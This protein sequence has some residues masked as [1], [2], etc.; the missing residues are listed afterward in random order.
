MNNEA[1]ADARGISPPGAKIGPQVKERRRQAVRRRNPSPSYCIG[2]LILCTAIVELGDGLLLHYLR[3]YLSPHSLVLVDIFFMISIIVPTFYFFV[4]RPMKLYELERKA[5]EEDIRFLSRKL[6]EAG[7]RERRIV[8][9]DMYDQLGQSLSV[10]QFSMEALKGSFCQPQIAQMTQCDSII[11][12]I[13]RLGNM[14]R[15]ASSRLSPPQ[16]DDLGLIPTLEWAITDIGENDGRF[17]IDFSS[18]LLDGRLPADIEHALY[19]A[20]K[21][22]MSNIASHASAV[23]VQISLV[24]TSAQVC[25]EIRD[26]GIGFEHQL[27][28]QMPSVR[29]VGL[30]GLR[31]RIES[32]GGEF[33]IDSEPGQGTRLLV[34]L[35]RSLRRKDDKGSRC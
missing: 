28:G 9:R 17:R 16:L 26:D 34:C 31:E 32:L 4:Y 20:F 30:L 33:I 29:G 6:I 35:P 2:V 24:G 8:A 5:A 10:L 12:S 14:V 19:A 7:D 27:T 21:E 18:R 15:G 3:P 11:E 22:A 13:S 25:L 23:Q 1:T